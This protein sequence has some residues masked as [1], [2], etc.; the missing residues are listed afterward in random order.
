MHVLGDVTMVALVANVKMLVETT[1]LLTVRGA[2][3]SAGKK[4]EESV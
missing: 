3:S 4:E 2:G 1:D